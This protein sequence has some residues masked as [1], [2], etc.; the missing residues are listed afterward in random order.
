M[1]LLVDVIVHRLG[2]A[3]EHRVVRF[4]LH[5]VAIQNVL[6]SVRSEDLPQ[7]VGMEH[8]GLVHLAP[9][10]RVVHLVHAVALVPRGLAQCPVGLSNHDQPVAVV[11]A[12]RDIR[13][14]QLLNVIAES[15]YFFSLIVRDFVEKFNYVLPDQCWVLVQHFVFRLLPLFHD[16]RHLQ[17]PLRILERLLFQ[18]FQFR[19][20]YVP[21]P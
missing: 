18:L 4:K 7:L 20:R 21:A 14:D 1:S 16:R 15:A 10:A 5:A 17:S 12:V 19:R 2:R 11:D 6:V 8:G 13:N 3:Y 9:L